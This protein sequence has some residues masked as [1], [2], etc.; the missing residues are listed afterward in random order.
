MKTKLALLLGIVCFILVPLN[1]SAQDGTINLT[2]ATFWPSSDFQVKK[3]H[4]E[5]IQEVEERT[6]GKV[7]I[8]L[9][10]GG[11]LLGGRE[12]YNGVA[13]GVADIGTTCPA[14]TPGEFP[15]MEA[16][17]LPGYENA[18]AVA[19][20]MTVHEGYKRMQ[21][22]LGIDSFEDVK[23]LM[24][25]A[26]G[27][28]DIMSKEPVRNLD[29][30][31]GM[32]LRAV[33]ATVEPLERLGAN[34]T[35]M[36]MSEAYTSLQQGIV[37]GILGPNDVLRGFRLAEVVNYVTKT[38]FLYNIVFMKVM[39]KRT[40]NS[41]P[42]DVQ[43]VF[44]DLNQEYAYK[45]GKLRARYTREGL[46]YGKKEHDMEVIRLSQDQEQKWEQ[47]IEPVV[48]NWIQEK[49]ENDLPA[50]ET[51]E[52]IKELDKKYSDKYSQY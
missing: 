43:K 45:Y 11:A 17:E 26:T 52:I 30:L 28:G 16:F 41:L 42:P 9:K 10:S 38:P 15:L 13:S 5:W 25:W 3:G 22:Q 50:R 2:F 47:K 31:Q 1:V 39:N 12:I 35:G 44:E 24:L 23:L 27:P 32:S 18:N 49:E 34:P 36:P 19:A 7:N 20:S 37:D 33:G 4:M 29:D 51:I 21:K 46:Q 14:Y 48:D 6:D 40:W 8:D